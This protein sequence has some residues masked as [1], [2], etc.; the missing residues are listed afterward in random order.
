MNQLQ[1]P[2]SKSSVGKQQ[3]RRNLFLRPTRHPE[4]F[5]ERLGQFFFE[6][7]VL[8]GPAL[9]RMLLPLAALMPMFMRFTRVRELYST[10]GTPVQMFEVYGQGPVLPVL[11]PGIAIALYS[12]MVF[13]L[14]CGIVGWKTRLSLGVGTALYV[15]F[16]L[17]DSVGTM[18]KY[19][20]IASHLLLLLTVSRCGSVWSVDAVL[21]R[22]RTGGSTDLPP[23]SPVWP[24]RLMQ[25]L[26]AFVYFGSAITKIQTEAFF[27]GE[28][29]RYWMLSNWNYDNPVGEVMAMW[30]PVLLIS[31]Y[32]TAVW[33][34]LF[35]F[36]VWN[37]RV[38]GVILGIGVIF[39]VMTCLTLGLYIFPAI[40][41]SGYLCFVTQED[42]LRARQLL[43]RSG[44][45]LDR[46]FRRLPALLP[47]LLPRLLPSGVV[48]T[49]AACLCGAATLEFEYQ[50][51]IY[52]MRRESGPLPLAELEL[53][54]ARKMIAGARPVREKDKFF[55]FGLG[56]VTVGGQLANRRESYRYGDWMIAECN[57][58][59]PHEDMW[60]EC[61]LEDDQG[62]IIARMGQFVTREMLRAR[63]DYLIGN[64]L[65]SGRYNMVL[66]SSGQEIYRCPFAVEGDISAE[67]DADS[68]P[69]MSGLLSN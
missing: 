8:W 22:R 40:C 41:L 55:S 61:I 9:T 33:E 4:G 7:Q 28:Q 3:N 21:R 34:I 14:V 65:T 48:W 29:M 11:P 16:N 45:R 26:Y 17:L 15:Y 18:T 1:A 42:V 49:S 19:S 54:Q 10:D 47:R 69:L 32:L 35:A 27:S 44:I 25:M 2:V 56:T 62:R 58:N 52:G 60:V 67:G 38:R 39:H 12:V 24:V 5:S 13:S 63:F 23:V 46:L 31:A 66:Q 37:H 53:D 59:P 30:S 50:Y 68:T 64:R 51:D 57:L 43:H 6:E 20:V 36:V